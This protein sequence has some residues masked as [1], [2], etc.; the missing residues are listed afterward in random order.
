MTLSMTGFGRSEGVLEEKKISVEV[1]SLNSKS[2]DMSIRVPPHFREKEMEIRK[3]L[4][5]RLIRGKIDCYISCEMLGGQRGVKI[6]KDIVRSYIEDL[7]DCAGDGPDI[8][9]LKMAVRLPEALSSKPGELERIDEES[10]DFLK[11]LMDEACRK[12]ED[13]R[14]K[15]G[16]VLRNDVL[17][18]VE[19]ISTYLG[20]V[21]PYEEQRIAG[22]RERYEK[23]LKEF[24]NI[25]EG[26][27]YQELMYYTE[28]LDISEEKVR[29]EQHLFYFREVLD[30]EE[31][32]G[33][34]LGFIAQEIG[35]EI[36]TLGSKANHVEIQK[37]VVKM[38]DELEKIK[39]QSLNI[40]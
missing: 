34:K 10:W 7:R 26:R 21:L 6:D 35:R 39:E 33:K 22:I 14:K 38:K 40:L 5:D 32:N 3:F 24:E 17:G 12:L 13:F 2:L 9:Y 4:N 27:Y 28:K 15:E 25:D 23:Y 19:K 31:C 8:E 1:K 11:D 29:L 37:L 30:R 18:A 16:E 20:E 36:N